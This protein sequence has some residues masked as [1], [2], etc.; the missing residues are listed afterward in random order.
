MKLI[1]TENTEK[2]FTISIS[3]SDLGT[4]FL[5]LGKCS[6][7]DIKEHR[8]NYCSGL[9]YNQDALGVFQEVKKILSI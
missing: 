5:T 1:K 8:D 2:Q 3:E 6:D 9:R 4:I 7:M